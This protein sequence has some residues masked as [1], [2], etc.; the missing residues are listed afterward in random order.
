MPSLRPVA[1]GSVPSLDDADA[2]LPD[3]PP[4]DELRE[5]LAALGDELDDLQTRLFA[6]ARRGLIVVLQARDAGGKDGV[7]RHV[8]GLFNPQGLAIRSFG[9]PTPLELNHDYLW[10]VHSAVG[11]R[12]MITVFNR[13]HY[14]DVL[15]VRVHE[16][17]PEAVW[18]TRYDQINGF[19]A[20]LAANGYA[21]LKFFLHVSRKEQRERLEARLDDPAKNWQFRAG[22][23]DER[24]RWDDYTK[25]YQDMLARCSTERAPWFVVPADSKPMRDLLIARTIRDTLAEMKL[26]YPPADPSV[27]AWKGKVQ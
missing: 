18:R 1:P 8:F 6:S 26:E 17:V 7:V 11:P 22:D 25:A 2:R 5:Q 9:V 27:L 4:K 19:E 10:R 16:L 24:A 3:T 20:M 13:S 12:G 14:E 15:V 21:I 23:L